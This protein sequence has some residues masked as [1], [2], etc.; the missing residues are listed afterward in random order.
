MRF[1]LFS[2]KPVFFLSLSVY[3]LFFYVEVFIF[4]TYGFVFDSFSH[5]RGL[6]LLSKIKLKKYVLNRSRA[7]SPAEIE[8]CRLILMFFASIVN[9]H[10]HKHTYIL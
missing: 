1:E 2:C 6:R 9:K 3:K 8:D 7:P 5:L 10:K 4:K